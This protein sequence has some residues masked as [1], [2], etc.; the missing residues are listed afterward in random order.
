ME[1]LGKIEARSQ[2]AKHLEAEGS[3]SIGQ[4]AW[5][6]DRDQ[7]EAFDSGAPSNV[8]LMRFTILC[9]CSKARASLTWQGA[10]SYIPGVE[11][12]RREAAMAAR[13]LELDVHY[14]SIQ[15]VIVVDFFL[16]KTCK[17]VWEIHL[18]S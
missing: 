8:I 11:F 5:Q 12:G 6:L 16:R 13:S 17:S 2:M 18:L 3:R 1:A 10:G 9:R 4:Q 7:V 15:I 14:V